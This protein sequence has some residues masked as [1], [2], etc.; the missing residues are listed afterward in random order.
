M[1]L[2]IMQP[3]FFPYIGYFALIKYT[4][5]WIVF[6]T[7][8]YIEKGWINR[9]RIIHPTQPEATYFTIPLEKHKQSTIIKDIK[10]SSDKSYK[11]KIIGQLNTSYKKRAP[12]FKEVMEVV[13]NCLDYEETD[14]TKLNIY[15]MEK[16]CEYIG[17]PFKYQVFS[18]MNLEIEQVSDPGEWALNISKALKVTSY[19]NPPGGI[20]LFSKEKFNDAGIALEF[21]KPN[22]CEYNQKKKSFL[23][24][25]S[26]IDVMMFNSKEEIIK[27]LDDFEIIGK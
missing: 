13:T 8:Q 11:D 5:K 17:I 16:V 12:Y 9:N 20:E 22:L 24:G 25:L 10:I 3:Y 26:I 15:A 18:K 2:G 23:P 1:K 4:D 6:D 21:L 19:V 14:L 7:V 27:M